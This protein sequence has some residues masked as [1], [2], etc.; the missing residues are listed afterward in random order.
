MNMAKSS[1]MDA[2]DASD[3]G[4]DESTETASGVNAGKGNRAVAAHIKNLHAASAMSGSV[5][6]SIAP[7][8]TLV[9]A[10]NANSNTNKKPHTTPKLKHSILT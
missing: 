6:S 9:H 8:K 2:E 1:Q 4:A 10:Q 5:S 3:H 7:S